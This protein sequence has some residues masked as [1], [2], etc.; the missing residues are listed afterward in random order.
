MAVSA[1][2][3]PEEKTDNHN[4]QSHC[5]YSPHSIRKENSESC[6]RTASLC[7]KKNSKE[8]IRKNYGVSLSNPMLS[9]TCND[10]N[11]KSSTNVNQRQIVKEQRYN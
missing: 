8:T 1:A 7:F 10:E 3:A 2:K 5:S 6:R 11:E 4:G 9:G